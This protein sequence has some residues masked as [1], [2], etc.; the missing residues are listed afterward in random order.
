ML[1]VLYIAC[2]DSWF[3]FRF[4]IH[5][6]LYSQQL[7]PSISAISHQNCT[8]SMQI[9]TR[10]AWTKGQKKNGKSHNM[11]LSNSV[12]ESIHPSLFGRFCLGKIEVEHISFIKFH[13]PQVFI[14]PHYQPA[15]WAP[16]QV[17]GWRLDNDLEEII[18]PEDWP[19]NVVWECCWESSISISRARC[20]LSTKV[21]WL[22]NTGKHTIGKVNIQAWCGTML[23][24]VQTGKMKSDHKPGRDFNLIRMG[25][26]CWGLTTK[27]A[28]DIGK[29]QS[30]SPNGTNLPCYHIAVE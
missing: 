21:P 11:D 1:N 8:G 12:Y 5:Q 3:P 27:C 14:H 16:K 20:K 23:L 13:G 15:M 29:T 18:H 10:K 22:P 7:L 25:G 17:Q 4:R 2:L 28:I 19:Q 6:Q 9:C 26:K 30:Q 24:D